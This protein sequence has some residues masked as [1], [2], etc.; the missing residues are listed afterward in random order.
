MTFNEYQELAMGTMVKNPEHDNLLSLARLTLGLSDEA[1]EVAGKVKKLLR[2][3]SNPEF[4]KHIEHELGDVLWYIA[5]VANHLN[6]NL[7]TI[8]KTNIAKL[9]DRKARNKIKG[10]GDNR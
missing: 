6:I 1:G 5:A 8:A 9:A 4:T 3:D 7:E 2:G 10:S